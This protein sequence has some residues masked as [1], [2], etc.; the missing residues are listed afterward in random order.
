MQNTEYENTYSHEEFEALERVE[1]LQNSYHHGISAEGEEVLLPPVRR[2]HKILMATYHLHTAVHR[3]LGSV[4]PAD[5]LMVLREWPHTSETDPTRVAYTRDDKGGET[6]RQTITSL[7]KYMARHWPHV[8]DH[9]RRDWVG[10]VSPD[11]FELWDT[12][13]DIIASAELGPTSCMASS[14]DSIPFTGDRHTVAAWR[15]DKRCDEPEWDTHPYAVYAPKFGWSAAVRLDS[16]KK[17][18]ARA[19][20]LED[21]KHKCFVR[22]YRSM[23][24]E[25]SPSDEQLEAWLK[26]QGYIKLGG[27]PAGAKLDALDH[28]NDSAYNHMLPYL[29]GRPQKVAYCGSHFKVDHNGDFE[30]DHTDGGYDEKSRNMVQC[31]GCGEEFDAD[32]DSYLRAG[33]DE[34]EYICDSCSSDYVQVTGASAGYRARSYTREYYVHEDRVAYIGE[35]AFD[36]ENLPNTVV[37]LRGGGS[38]AY[39]E[40]AVEIDD[41]WYLRDDGRICL[42]NDT[43]E[44]ALRSDCWQDRHGA[45]FSDAQERVMWCGSAYSRDDAESLGYCEEVQ[46]EQGV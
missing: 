24:G 38:Y 27:W 26:V 32:E 43:D 30:C 13:E 33:P 39:R 16:C 10:A 36:S 18:Q 31:E 41:D 35:A 11:T 29:D 14:Y 46:T 5:P 22:S 8:P 15:A 40:D 42:A 2:W 45:W 12:R 34:D 3:A 25:V 21:A 6:N 7:G 9:V 44:W 4:K 1:A 23:P 28:P 17:I 37:E 19:L 20:V